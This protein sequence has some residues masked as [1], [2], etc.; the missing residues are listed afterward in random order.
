MTIK[1]IK[2]KSHALSIA[3]WTS[4]PEASVDLDLCAAAKGI[5]GLVFVMM[6]DHWA[7]YLNQ[8]SNMWKIKNFT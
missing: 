1:Q 3:L 4:L 7:K 5:W 8:R 6:P 2:K